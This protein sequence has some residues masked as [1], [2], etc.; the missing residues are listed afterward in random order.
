MGARV[1]VG[2]FFNGKIAEM[3][4]YDVALNEAQIQALIRKGS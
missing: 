3:K 1:N 2:V 4:V